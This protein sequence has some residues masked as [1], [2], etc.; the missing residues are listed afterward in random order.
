MRI[1]DV[2]SDASDDGVETVA[3]QKLKEHPSNRG[4]DRETFRRVQGARDAMLD[5]KP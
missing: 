3:R 2:S 5:G 1:L 4:G